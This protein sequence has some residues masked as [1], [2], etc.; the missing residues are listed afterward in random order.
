MSAGGSM[1]E[2]KALVVVSLNL[3]TPESVVEVLDA[4]DAPRIPHFAGQVRVVVEPHATQVTDWLD[5]NE[6]AW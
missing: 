3:P 4:L 6:V 2:M 5:G 1:A